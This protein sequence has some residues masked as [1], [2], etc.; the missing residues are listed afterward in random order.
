MPEAQRPHLERV[1][2]M[3][4]AQELLGVPTIDRASARPRMEVERVK[5]VT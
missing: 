3:R 5:E 2:T 4:V 1:E